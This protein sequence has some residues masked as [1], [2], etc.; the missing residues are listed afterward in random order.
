M[1]TSNATFQEEFY[2]VLKRAIA[3]LFNATNVTITRVAVGSLIVDYEFIST[4]TPSQV[5]AVV[6]SVNASHGNASSIPEAFLE[7][8]AFYGNVTNSTDFVLLAVSSV[9]VITSAPAAPTPVCW[10]KRTTCPVSVLSSVTF[11]TACNTLAMNLQTCLTSQC[12]NETKG[13][14]DLY[15]SGIGF[16]CNTSSINAS[17]YCTDSKA[18]LCAAYDNDD[19][20]TTSAA[21]TTSTVAALLVASVV[22]FLRL[23]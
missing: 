3:D 11:P 13:I 12:H 21:Q 8:A 20:T 9:L 6:A 17:L 22:A 23:F 2:G 18:D 15:V 5:S 10:T 14:L 16:L 1:A 7:L 19:V 4:L